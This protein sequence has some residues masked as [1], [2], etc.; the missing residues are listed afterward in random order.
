MQR[1][2]ATDWEELS[3]EAQ[4][5]RRKGKRLPLTFPIAVSGFVKNGRMFGEAT[6]TTDVSELGCRFTL[7]TPVASG[8]IVAIKLLSRRDGAT[9]AT[10]PLLFRIVWVHRD[11]NLWNVGAFKLQP[12]NIWHVAFPEKPRPGESAA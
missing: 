8:D 10:A 11:G 3:Q 12:E 1:S 2:V 4:K 7:K 5:D 6:K 9:P